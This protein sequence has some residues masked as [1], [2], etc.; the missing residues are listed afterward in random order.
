[1]LSLKFFTRGNIDISQ[2]GILISLKGDNLVVFYYLT[3]FEIWLDKMDGLWWERP[4]KRA[5]L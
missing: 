4:G 5:Y 2:G 1:V 3:A